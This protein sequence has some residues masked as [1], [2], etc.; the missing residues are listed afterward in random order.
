M[1]SLGIEQLLTSSAHLLKG[2]RFAFL[3]HAAACVRSGSSSLA[4]I[5]AFFPGQLQVVWIPQH[6]FYG[7]KQANMIPS[8]D[9]LDPLTGIPVRSLY[10]DRRRPSREMFTGIDLVLVDLVDV[11]CRVYT[12]LWTL[13]LVMQAAAEA[14]VPVMVLD[15]P[16]PLGGERVEGNLLKP[17]NASFVGLYPLPMR[18]GLSLGELARYLNEVYAFG[19]QLEVMPMTGWQRKH[20]ADKTDTFWV[21]P[22]PNMPTLTTA[23]VYPG[24][25]LFEG[26]NLSEGRGTTTP[27]ELWGAPFIEPGRILA[28]ID[29]R[30]SRGVFLRPA[31]FSPTFDKWFGGTDKAMSPQVCGGLQIHVTDR[32][33]FQPYL[34]SLELLR[35]VMKL[36]GD[37]FVWLQPPYEYEDE[38]LPIDILTGDEHIRLALENGEDLVSLSESWLPELQEFCQRRQ[39]FLLY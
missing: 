6:G 17:E 23:L 28:E 37:Q 36:Y 26:T 30:V 14:G 25:V 22:S 24:Q 32:R 8:A 3:T 13:V 27:F 7:V 34:L 4:E 15:R 9:F 16:N 33:L 29:L 20:Y 38:K 35:V 31:Y 2:K 12:Y 39:E 10:G 5:M 21:P 18:H 19:C 11:G 1:I